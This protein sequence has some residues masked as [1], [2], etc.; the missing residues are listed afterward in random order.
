[1]GGGVF[2]NNSAIILEHF[3]FAYNIAYC[4]TPPINPLGGGLCARWS[5]IQL[6][7]GIFQYN[8]AYLGGAVYLEY[9]SLMVSNVKFSYNSAPVPGGAIC[10]FNTNIELDRAIFS[11]NSGEW[12]T[13]YTEVTNQS[14]CN[15]Q[16][17]NCLFTYNQSG[18]I[19]LGNYFLKIA[20]STLTNN[21]GNSAVSF[22]GPGDIHIINSIFWDNGAIE[23]ETGSWNTVAFIGY[24]D[25]K[26]GESGLEI[27]G[28]LSLTGPIYDFDPLFADSS[29][30]R[31]SDSSPCIGAGIDSLTVYPNMTAPAYDLD[32]L[33]RPNPT[34]SMPD[35]G[36]YENSLANPLTGIG[37]LDAFSNNRFINI[38]P[39]PAGEH[40]TIVN[41]SG[42]TI[43]SIT[44]NNL[45]GIELLSLNDFSI[46]NMNE[47]SL[48]LEHLYMK[49]MLV[50]TFRT[51]SKSFH[52]ILILH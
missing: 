2:C 19:I 50:V 41:H 18:I 49:G 15:I 8:Q 29:N 51:A 9:C 23:I 4:V 33:M 13:I 39:N 28:T 27:S 17:S 5:T 48:S 52:N 31:L 46:E 12:G 7:H 14:D 11:H 21:F 32:S 35:L 37:P 36:A 24:S 22:G 16:I 20:N 34:L 6:M 25:F 26:G 47:L 1:M 10:A 38:F 3:N 44:I 40:I 43:R 42:E 30:F 45:E